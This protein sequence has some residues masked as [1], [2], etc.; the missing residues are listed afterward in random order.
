MY[1]IAV[2]SL[3]IAAALSY[4]LHALT[5]VTDLKTII[6]L[7]IGLLVLAYIA[8]I[9]LSLAKTLPRNK[10]INPDAASRASRSLA[11]CLPTAIVLLAVG[12]FEGVTS[13]IGTVQV[14]LAVIVAVVG[15][16]A[17]RVTPRDD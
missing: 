15:W 14:T 7:F 3:I 13:L 16:M 2:F 12:I 4:V 8:N 1:L 17:A 6:I 9:G 10:F 11:F 5:F